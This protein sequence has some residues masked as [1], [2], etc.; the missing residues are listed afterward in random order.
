MTGG[1]DFHGLAE[2]ETGNVGKIFIDIEKVKFLT[3]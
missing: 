1:S 2:D 3:K